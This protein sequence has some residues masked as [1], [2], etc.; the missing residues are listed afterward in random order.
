VLEGRALRLT[1][2]LRPVLRGVSLALRPGEAVALMGPNGAGKTTLLRVLGLLRRPDGGTVLMG[3]R[4][5]TT[6][7]VAPRSRIGFLMHR[8]F[9]DPALSAEENLA[10]FARLFGRSTEG[11]PAALKEV[12]LAPFGGDPVKSFSEGMTRRLELGRLLLQDP[13]YWLLD[14]PLSGL[15]EGGRALVMRLIRQAKGGGAAVLIVSHEVLPDPGAVDRTLRL[16]RGRLVEEE[17]A[18]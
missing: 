12:G 5:V 3:G 10:F 7:D 2:G 15:D 11:I 14:E 18:G 6:E 17:T 9:A 8:P 4:E 13:S 1:L 16:G